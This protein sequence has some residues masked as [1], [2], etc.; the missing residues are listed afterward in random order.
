[1]PARDLYHNQL[2]NA[3]IKDGW[4]ITNDPLRLRWGSKDMYVDLGAE[5]ILTAEKGTKKIA[6]ELKT[7]GGVSEVNEIENTIGQYVVYR[8]VMIRT[9]QDRSLYLAVHKEIFTDIFEEPLGRI[10]IEDYQI[11]LIVFDF[12]TEEIVKWIP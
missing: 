10:L 7:F 3:L 12:Q 4:I 2:K 5:Q 6:V 1:M 11:R 8:S 9:E